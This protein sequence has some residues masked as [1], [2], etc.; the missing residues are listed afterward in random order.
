MKIKHIIL[1]GT[2]LVS[3]ASFA[4]KD[5]LKALKKI[6]AKDEIANDDLNEYKSLITKLESLATEE[7]DK[8][9]TN[10]YKSMLP[11]LELNALGLDKTLT[12]LQ[13]QMKIA[14]SITPKTISDFEK[15]LN[16][17]LDYEKKTGKKIYT[18]DII[19]TIGSFKSQFLNYAIALGN[20][21][22]Y[23]ESAEV[24]YS[25]YLLD[26]K[27]QEN[28]YYA[29]NY[30]VNGQDYDNALKYFKELKATNYTGE[31]TVYYAKNKTTGTEEL[32]N[33]KAVR[34]KLVD[35]GT[36]SAPR[37]EKTPSKKAEIVR[38]IALILVDQGKST[39]AKEAIAEARKLNPDDVGLITSEADIYLKLNDTENYKRLI[40]EALAKNP[41][42]KILLFNLGVTSSNANQLEEAEKYYRKVIE[43]D[44]NYT[45][46]YMNLAALLLKPDDKI[47]V[48][49]NK[50][51][52]SA[53]DLKKYDALKAE[54]V[55]LFTKVMPVLE[56]AHQLDP[57]NESAKSNLKS[58]YSFL[59][60]MDKVKALKE[61]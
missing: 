14:K 6:Y 19:E 35:L 10:F 17:T 23:K 21:K 39:E 1:T 40:N 47:V 37:E 24:L 50:L 16:A 52:N 41:N 28:L 27:D 56:K 30:A 12:P 42:D 53:S 43:I 29:A 18:D 33:D 48:E 15:G 13:A 51:T 55:K 59:E 38:T 34:D 4:Q 2:L 36:H 58:V 8:V 61:E 57:K 54:R 46:A 32:Y 31:G 22:K 20:Q 26:K 49:M 3:V 60:L 45:D 5:E 25:I 44:P 11:A 9:Y 7:G